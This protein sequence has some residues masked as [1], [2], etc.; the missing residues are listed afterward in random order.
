MAEGDRYLV[1]PQE[2]AARAAALTHQVLAF[3][4]RQ[5]LEPKPTDAGALVVG[6]EEL[7]RRTVGPQIE[8][9]CVSDDEV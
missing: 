7:I 9:A 5:M 4:R 2:A 8:V 6:V 1:A 3:S